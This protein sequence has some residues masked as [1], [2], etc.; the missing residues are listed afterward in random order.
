MEA[1]P[2]HADVAPAAAGG[3]CHFIRAI[4]GTRIRVGIWRGGSRGTVLMFPGRTEYIEK[5]AHVAAAMEKAGYAT[6]II[7]WRGQ[8]LADR[9]LRDPMMGHVERF[10]DYQL[11]VAAALAAADRAG[12]PEPYFLMAHS[13]GG[14]IGLRA[15]TR[16]LQ[17]RAAAFS[18]PMWGILMTPAQRALAWPLGLAARTLGGDRRF[19]PTTDATTYVAT[20]PFAGN[21]L[22]TDAGMYALMQ[23]QV[24][25][26]PELALGGPSL[27][28]LTEALIET[29]ALAAL[30]APGVPAVTAL[31]T[32]E[33]VVDAGAVRKRM[34]DWP[35]GRL[36]LYTGAEHE[37]IMERPAH[38]SRFFSSAIAL[39]DAH[40]GQAAAGQESSGTGPP[41]APRRRPG[42]RSAPG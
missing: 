23:T 4:D 25:A 9:P 38:L 7:D 29:R 39:F 35:G 40:G 15:L 41:P 26:H 24:A 2:L 3:A 11:D 22:T 21:V 8:G 20:A 32:N 6:L 17:V 1:A 12:L 28:W 19:A 5:Y 30:P 36:D 33:R 37:V 31:G 16:G 42:V 13:M 27:H 34:A 14:C 18:G 10:T